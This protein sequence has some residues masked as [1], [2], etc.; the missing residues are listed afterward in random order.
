MKNVLSEDEDL[1][2]NKICD[3]VTMNFLTVPQSSMNF[4]ENILH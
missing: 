3:M 1:P 2:A 4:N